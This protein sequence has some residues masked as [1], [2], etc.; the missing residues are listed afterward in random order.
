ML[1]DIYPGTTLPMEFLVQGKYDEILD[2]VHWR[3]LEMT[4]VEIKFKT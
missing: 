2:K 4:R 3:A 1:D